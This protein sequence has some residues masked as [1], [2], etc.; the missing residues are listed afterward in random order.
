MLDAPIKA[1]I[2]AMIVHALPDV[3]AIYLFGSA[4]KGEMRVDSDIDLALLLA[5]KPDAEAIFNLK[6]Q[7]TSFARKDIDLIDLARADTVTQ[8]QVVSGSELLFTQ[9]ASFSAF[10]ETTV[11]SQYAQLNLERR[12]I[13]EDIIKR[14][15]IYGR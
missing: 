11:L 13:L 1:K 6:S 7:L 10:F 15:S 12:E 2:A 3:Q 4:A 5:T 9:N 8:A 14:G